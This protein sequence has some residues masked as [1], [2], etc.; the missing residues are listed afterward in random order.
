MKTDNPQ[1]HLLAMTL[2]AALLLPVLA[3]AASNTTTNV[4]PSRFGQRASDEA[5]GAFQRGLYKTALNLALARAKDGDAAAQTLAAEIYARGL[6]TAQDL[7][8]A[9]RLYNLAAEKGIPE[10]QFQAALFLIEGKAGTKNKEKAK[11]YLEKA[12]AANHTLAAFNLA[13]LILSDAS[14]DT[15]KKP[16]FDLF[17]RAAQTGLPDAQYAVSQFLANGSGGAPFDE[18]Q[19]RG[20]L[21]KAARQN[22]D[23][24]QLDLG[25]WLID[26]VG[27]KKDYEA[28]FLWIKRA[29]E[30][31][32]VEAQR[33]LAHLYEDGIGNKGDQISAAAWYVIA[34]RVGLH[35]EALDDLL[36]GLT[37]EEL[38]KAI[39]MANRL[40]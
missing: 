14:T 22:Y 39:E 4:D 25:T 2:A 40:K 9:S 31:G 32:N 21:E 5:F 30:I 23:T 11:A 10:A 1:S 38:K 33:R 17:L 24:A 15:Q 27:G 8:E 6:G 3:S 12:V 36:D 16:A 35:D 28:G 37:P 26:G 34:R 20:W 7:P 13:Q 29:A 19:A 18:V